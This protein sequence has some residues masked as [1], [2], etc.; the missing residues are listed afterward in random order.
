[1]Q[2]DVLAR[3][4]EAMAS[5]PLSG[6]VPRATLRRIGGRRWRA[7]V[8]D[9][10]LA[11]LADGGIITGEDR[12][13]RATAQ[14]PERDPVDVRVLESI[15]AA[16]LAGVTVADL[17][18]TGAVPDRKSLAAVLSRLARSGDVARVGDLYVSH[19][20]LRGLVEDLRAS[21]GSGGGTGRVEIG[22]FKDRYGL[23]RRA[24]IPLL[25]WL[26]RTRVTRREGDAR[27][28]IDTR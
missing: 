5:D 16:A 21:A 8:T 14:A 2:Q 22:W 1:M 23:T 13:T 3:L 11:R 27:V 9:L 12:I 4:D 28:V 17:E 6:G 26:D 24:A 7:E 20:R 18:G 19:T 15:D 10:V 25:E